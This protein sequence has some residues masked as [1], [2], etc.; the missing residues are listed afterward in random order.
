[1]S[2]PYGCIGCLVK[3]KLAASH[4]HQDLAVHYV[5]V[6]EYDP[7]CKVYQTHNT[8]DPSEKF[9]VLLQDIQMEF[10]P[11]FATHISDAAEYKVVDNLDMK[12]IP[13]GSVVYFSLCSEP[14]IRGGK[15]FVRGSYNFVGTGTQASVEEYSLETLLRSCV[16]VG[17]QNDDDIIE[18]QHIV[19]DLEQ[20]SHNIIC[21]RGTVVFKGCYFQGR[22]GLKVG[23]G[24]ASVSVFLVGCEF[25][26]GRDCSVVV[27]SNA[28]VTMINTKMSGSK[29]GV[30]VK[31]GGTFTAH[32]CQLSGNSFGVV[33]SGERSNAYLAHCTLDSQEVCGLL[34]NSGNVTMVKCTLSNAVSCG[35]VLGG[36]GPVHAVLKECIL[37]SC[38]CGLKLIGDVD[39]K[40]SG[41]TVTACRVGIFATSICSGDVCF[42]NNNF[43]D[44][45]VNIANFSNGDCCKLLWN[46]MLK[47][48]QHMRIEQLQQRIYTH[49]LGFAL[50]THW[51]LKVRR[52]LTHSDIDTFSSQQ[53][54]CGG[55]GTI[56][57][58]PKAFKN[59]NQ[60]KQ[61]CYCAR[62]CQHSHW[63]EHRKLCNISDVWEREFYGL[64]YVACTECHKVYRRDDPRVIARNNIECVC[65]TP[66]LCA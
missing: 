21:L 44:C 36:M 55:C 8:S 41:L 53:A 14:S 42:T 57:P 64:G 27:E 35:I 38:A 29:V 1:M 31:D 48:S 11:N 16:Y 62:Q 5:V 28:Q 23:S 25:V 19:F 51:T 10:T 54:R 47:I 49:R 56:E 26:N 9:C 45:D 37:S 50:L 20:G 24:K 34:A 32:H 18:F 7:D 3:R 59:C 52:L 4:R 63:K 13:A 39:L 40:S 43:A 46:G 65:R 17:A 22:S 12:N 30:S 60:C 61:V 58:A 33:T 6:D 2:D 15:L 66:Q